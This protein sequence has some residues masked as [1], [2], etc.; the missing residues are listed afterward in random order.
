MSEADNNSWS[1]F[2]SVVGAY[3]VTLHAHARAGVMWSG[4]VSIYVYICLW[5]KKIFESYFSDRLTFSNIRSRTSCWIYRLA[6][7]LRTP[8]TLSSLSKSRVSIFNAH[9]TLFVRRMMSHNSMG[10]YRYLVK[11]TWNL[12]WNGASPLTDQT[13]RIFAE[14]ERSGSACLV[15]WLGTCYGNVTG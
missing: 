13:S 7:P 6:L 2:I 5:T 14:L 11:L 10:K 3:V 9:L 1:I 4:L 15:N 8:E 12:P